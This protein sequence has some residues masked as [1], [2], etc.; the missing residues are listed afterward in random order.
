MMSAGGRD[1]R[2]CS[3]T[4]GRSSDT[5][6]LRIVD[7]QCVVVWV[8]P[9]FALVTGNRRTETPHRSQSDRQRSLHR[10]FLCPTTKSHN[11]PY[12]KQRRSLSRS[13]RPASTFS[14]TATQFS[15]CR[16]FLVAP[17]VTR[18]TR[19]M[20][21]YKYRHISSCLMLLDS[22]PTGRAKRRSMR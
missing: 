20:K 16:R 19:R 2:M 12:S 10:H 18:G 21:T 3:K 17:L 22:S 15:G 1:N 7:S 5:D 13:S 14:S 8:D 4:S 11:L 9:R 6:V